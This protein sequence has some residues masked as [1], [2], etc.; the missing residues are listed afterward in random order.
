MT[1]GDAR[2][3]AVHWPGFDGGFAGQVAELASS[4]RGIRFRERLRDEFSWG[5]VK[6]LLLGPPVS[7]GRDHGA[8]LRRF[9]AAYH[10]AIEQIVRLSRH[11]V[12][13]QRVLALPE[14][15]SADLGGDADPL[16]HGDRVH[17][18]RLDLFLDGDGGFQ[19]LETNANCP[20]L[21]VYS[22]DACRIWRDFL[23]DEEIRL[24]APLPNEDPEWIARWFL[25]VAE[26][27]TGVRPTRV[28]LLRAGGGNRLELP[29]QAE[30]LESVGVEAF[31]VDPKEISLASDGTPTVFGKSFGHAYLKLGIQ[32]FLE[33]RSEFDALVEA[34]KGGRLFVQNGLRGRWV[35]DN[36]LCLAVLSDP[37][38]E[39]LF[40]P[41]IRDRL[42]DHI[43]WSRNIGLCERG[44]VEQVK[45]D[46]DAFVLKS[47]LDTRGK[48]VVMGREVAG[49]EWVAAVEFAVENR[50]LV[51][52]QLESTWLEADFNDP[53][54]FRH[55]LAIG[56]INGEVSF[57]FVRS[58]PEL[59]VNVARSG[60][61][62][63]VFIDPPG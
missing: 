28:P 18:C 53:A 46:K 19:V 41:H 50:W 35:G 43:P 12:D 10:A 40:E 60:R 9:T 39:H 21:L 23:S 33:R 3:G 48:G 29:D 24:P 37:A 55:D 36:K 2:G 22:G 45:S 25:D 7:I 8:Q 4:D 6:P 44:L 63:P 54:T 32:A 20:G 58:S 11:D 51:Q 17:L 27:A 16:L 13:V 26:E 1:N 52:E 30:R 31:E 38:F 62:H 49:D 56:A 59:R 5:G 42:A 15:L 61:M 34:I 14:A 47:P 57:A